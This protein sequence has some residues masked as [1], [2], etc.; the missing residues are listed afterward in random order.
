MA[1]FSLFRLHGLVVKEFVQLKRDRFTMALI[2]G[3]PIIQ[4]LLF[5]L[6]INVNPKHLPT[7][8][9]NYDQGPFARTLIHG[10]ENTNYFKF[11][12][13][14][15]T[16]KEAQYLLSTNQVKFILTIPSDFSRKLI[17]K[18][19]PAAL[20]EADG[21][22]PVSVVYALSASNN[23]MSTVFNNDLI[24]SI[25]EPIQH[26]TPAELRTHINYNA[27]AITQYNIVPGLLGL[28]LSMTF[29]MVSAMALARERERGNWECLLATSLKPLE[30]MIGKSL[31][32]IVI[33]YLQVFI[34]L[35]IAVS[36]FRIP[37][38]GS[39][40]LFLLIILPFILA[41]LFV[42]IL[43]STFAKNQLEASQLSTLFMMPSLLLSGFAFPFKGMP[44]WAQFIGNLLPLT[45]FNNIVRGMMLKGIGFHEVMIDLGPILLFMCVSLFLALRFYKQTLD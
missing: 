7:A 4:L 40:W 39:L 20:L 17:R 22:D 24:G 25:H 12:Y 43:F 9:M 23:L 27:S 34:I 33:G 8:L 3:L 26:Q 44:Y 32:L 11:V 38:L 29:V 41:N 19:H 6:A 36:F 13:F 2:I 14:P 45:H 15:H 16:E 35:I 21:T 31:P 30:V 10:L 5:G 37:F 1:R 18:E 28:V 42:G